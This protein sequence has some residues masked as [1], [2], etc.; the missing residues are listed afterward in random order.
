MSFVGGILSHE[1]NPRAEAFKS[2]TARVV[3]Q[4]YGGDLAGASPTLP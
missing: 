3:S 1:T 2:M 4:V